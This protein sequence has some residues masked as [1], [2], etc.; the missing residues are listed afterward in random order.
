VVVVTTSTS[1]FTLPQD[2]GHD[3]LLQLIIEAVLETSGTAGMAVGPELKPEAESGHYTDILEPNYVFATPVPQDMLDFFHKFAQDIATKD[4]RRIAENYARGY[5][6]G[7]HNFASLPRRWR[8]MFGGGPGHLQYVHIT[9]IRIE[10]NRAYLRGNLKYAYANMLTGSIG[11]FPMENLIK[12][13][14]RW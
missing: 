9:K 14:G 5:E 3:R 8:R 11:L 7:R 2:N 10:N 6:N 13:K 4:I 1:R 12:L